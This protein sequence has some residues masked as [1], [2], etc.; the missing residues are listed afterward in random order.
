VTRGL[1][2]A[3]AFSCLLAPAAMAQ[4]PD[5]SKMFKGR[6]KPGMYEQ[7]DETVM[8]GYEGIPAANEKSTET[9]KRCVSQAEI[10]KGVELRKDCKFT[11]V[12]E[13]ANAVHYS[14]TCPGGTKDDFSLETTATGFKSRLSS[15]GKNAA[16]KPMEMSMV[17]EA[18]YLGPC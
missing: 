9:K 11:Q 7:K 2:L 15:V 13:S 1:L 16:G 18:K 14:G 6:V 5:G 10:D 17:S 8:R 12:K 4:A 3:A